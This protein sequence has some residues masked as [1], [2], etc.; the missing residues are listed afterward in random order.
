M[1]RVAFLRDGNPMFSLWI[2]TGKLAVNLLLLG[3]P[4]ETISFFKILNR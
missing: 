4:N 3:S 1:P 2:K